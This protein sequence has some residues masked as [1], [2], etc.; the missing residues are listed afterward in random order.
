MSFKCC[1][2]NPLSRAQGQG[3]YSKSLRDE[4]VHRK[5]VFSNW[6][7]SALNCRGRQL[8]ERCPKT[9]MRQLRPSG[10][11][12]GIWRRNRQVTAP[13]LDFTHDLRSRV[14]ERLIKA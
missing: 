4:R 12:S 3:T 6:S 2:L 9:E 10:L 13:D 5:P 14:Q 7:A 1:N 8:H 11:T